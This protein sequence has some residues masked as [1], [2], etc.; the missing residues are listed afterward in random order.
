MTSYYSA[1]FFTAFLPIAVMLYGIAP[2][3]FRWAV[4]LL[5]S[6][7]F[8]FALS[9]ALVAFVALS[10]VV[11]YA[12]AR[13]IDANLE[14]KNRQP[15]K[16]SSGK[17]EM[18]E[19]CKRKNRRIVAG[20]VVI[21]I[22]ILA[23][24]KYSGFFGVSL[25]S[26]LAAF[27]ISV[28][29]AIPSFALPIGISFYT[30]MAVSYVMDVY[31]ERT[32]ADKNLGHVALFL[33]FFPGIMEGP[34]SRYN[35]IAP[36][37]TAGEPLNRKNLYAGTLRIVW[38]MAKKIIVADRLNAFV[39]PVFDNYGSYDGGVIALAAILYTIQL[40]CDFSGTMD[41][42]LGM[43]RVFNVALPENF[44]QPFFSRTASEFWQRWHITLGLW[45]KDYV[46]YPISLS[47]PCKLLTTKA[48]KRF[49]N[50]YGPLLASA[51]ALFCVWI[52]NGL[53]HGAGSQYIFFGL[54]YFV[55]IMVGGLIEPQ[56]ARVAQ[57]F[58]INRDR[59]SY[60][61]LQTARTLVIIF[62]GELFFRSSS[63]EAGLAM[64]GRIAGNFTIEAFTT[65]SALQ[66]GFGVGDG[67]IV[68]LFMMLVLVVGVAKERGCNVWE[69]VAARRA[70]M[71]WGLVILLFVGTVT[72]GAYGIGYMPVDPMYA[73][74]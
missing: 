25:A 56:C 44:R 69:W 39:K 71:R 41:V 29:L 40:Y 24:L 32:K 27:G 52:G 13:M 8:F 21:N 20:A 5:A 61:A 65:G 34:L 63:L 49:G 64:V 47:K 19:A 15:A 7:G 11:V 70:P 6:Y 31:R 58:G 23:V 4:L 68:A 38:G 73:Q 43:G 26:V 14:K 18:R 74:F 3:R 72:F 66:I 28:D 60:R 10:T 62:I 2:R 50:R 51:V 55:L 17:R 35:D 48:R 59:W 1:L 33:A 45:F 42:A 9:G 16:A 30:L 12:C 57:H 37:L 54:Y 53:W 67:I 46:Y 36:S 22:G